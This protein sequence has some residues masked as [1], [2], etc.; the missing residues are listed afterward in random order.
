[1]YWDELGWILVGQAR[2]NHAQVVQYHSQAAWLHTNRDTDADNEFEC[3]YENKDSKHIISKLE[4]WQKTLL[5]LTLQ[6]ATTQTMKERVLKQSNKCC[7]TSWYQVVEELL[8]TPARF[9]LNKPDKLLL[10][11]LKAMI[12][13]S[14]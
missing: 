9:V 7:L 13:E 6:S 14:A 5:S 11:V 12:L 1:M 2:G 4:S 3:S 10:K 8:E